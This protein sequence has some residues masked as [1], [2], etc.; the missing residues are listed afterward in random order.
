MATTNTPVFNAKQIFRGSFN[1]AN[2]VVSFAGLQADHLV[3]NVT[4]QFAQQVGIIYEL[5]SNN[6]YMDGGRASGTAGMSRILSAAAEGDQLLSKYNNVCNPGTIEIRQRSGCSSSGQA[7][8]STS[9]FN[10]NVS[11]R[12]VLDAAVLTA[13]SGSQESRSSTF[14]EQMQFMFL[15]MTRE[16]NAGSAAA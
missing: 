8:R 6:A 2:N 16:V 13:L 14:A 11:S 1:I 12:V 5:G 10:P 4:Y 9:G 3:Q 7:A 15:D